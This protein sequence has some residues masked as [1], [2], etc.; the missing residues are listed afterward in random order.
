VTDYTAEII[1]AMQQGM[2]AENRRRDLAAMTPGLGSVLPLPQPYAD[3][4]QG[5]PPVVG[6]GYAITAEV[7]SAVRKAYGP[8][9]PQYAHPLVGGVDYPAGIH[10]PALRHVTNLGADGLFIAGASAP[11]DGFT[12]VPAPSWPSLLSRLLGRFRSPR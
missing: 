10:Q 8:D 4:G 2:D 1:A 11:A 5:S 3:A 7:A 9:R 12:V 6:E